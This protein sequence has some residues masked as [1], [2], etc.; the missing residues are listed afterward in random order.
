MSL[1]RVFGISQYGISYGLL[2]TPSESVYR[3]FLEFNEDV[4][5]SSQIGDL[6]YFINCLKNKGEYRIE[7]NAIHKIGKNEINLTYDTKGKGLKGPS[8]RKSTIALHALLSLME[9]IDASEKLNLPKIDSFKHSL[10]DLIIDYETKANH[11]HSI[12]GKDTVEGPVEEE[13]EEIEFGSDF[14]SWT[15][16]PEDH[17]GLTKNTESWKQFQ[18]KLDLE[19]GI[20]N[21][22]RQRLYNGWLEV[23]I[24]KLWEALDDVDEAESEGRHIMKERLMKEIEELKERVEKTGTSKGTCYS[25]DKWEIIELEG[26]NGEPLTLKVLNLKPKFR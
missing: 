1:E 24:D 11:S 2:K 23:Y 15:I 16:P 12:V 10:A 4:F 9:D 25:K 22:Y 7:T 19:N 20:E 26:N 21:L 17:W 6:L 14:R 3:I 5:P 13:Q 18:R 8:E